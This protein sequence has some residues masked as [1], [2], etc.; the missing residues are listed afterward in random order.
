M[1]GFVKHIPHL[2]TLLAFVLAKIDTQLHMLI[3]Y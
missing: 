2:H 1:L 3:M